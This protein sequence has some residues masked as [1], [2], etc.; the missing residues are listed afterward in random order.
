MMRG[1]FSSFGVAA[2][3]LS[4]LL[5]LAE[6]AAAQRIEGETRREQRRADRYDDGYR[7]D[8]GYWGYNRGYWGGYGPSW[9]YGRGFLGRGSRYYGNS[10]WYSGGTDGY[11][12][13]DDGYYSDSGRRRFFSGRGFRR[14]GDYYG[15]YSY[16]GCYGSGCTGG[17]YG[18][19]CYGRGCAGGY[20][21][22]ANSA[23]ASGATNG[24]SAVINVKVAPEAE[25][26]FDNFKTTQTGADRQFMTPPLE[27]NRDFTYELHVRANGAEQTRKITVHAGQQ[28][29]LDLTQPAEAGERAE[30]RGENIKA[31]Q[32][33]KQYGS[34]ARTEDKKAPRP[35]PNAS[36][37]QEGRTKTHEG[38]VI[39]FS[40][41][42]LVMKDAAGKEHRHTL[43]KDAKITIDGKAAKAEDLKPNMRI[44]VTIPEG[45][46]KTAL[47]IDAKSLE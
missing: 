16:G 35:E 2:V 24:S 10:G 3:S 8:R 14:G 44:E 47:R 1:V 38:Q 26:A 39:R 7:S 6:S 11:Y 20:Y 36:D 32:K 22:Q 40:D 5:L 23:M 33:A 43:A 13:A 27:P 17:Y 4:G 19:G 28:L 9:G 21:G 18:S 15:S 34:E 41:N 46:A 45:D 30:A 12:S 31:P 25:I 37:A 42:E 29:R